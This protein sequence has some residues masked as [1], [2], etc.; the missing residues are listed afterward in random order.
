LAATFVTLSGKR[1]FLAFGG[2]RL[3]PTRA[4]VGR[5]L[6]RFRLSCRARFLAGPVFPFIRRWCLLAIV[7]ATAAAGTLVGPAVG[8]AWLVR[9]RRLSLGIRSHIL[10]LL[11]LGPLGLGFILLVTRSRVG[12]ITDAVLATL[13]AAAVDGVWR[14]ATRRAIAGRVTC[15]FSGGL[16]FLGLGAGDLLR[17]LFADVLQRLF[18]RVAGIV[19][20]LIGSLLSGRAR[21]RLTLPAAL[22][23]LSALTLATVRGLLILSAGLGL[24]GLAIA[25]ARLLAA[26]VWRAVGFTGHWLFAGR[27]ALSL[28]FPVLRIAWLTF[29]RSGLTLLACAL[30]SVTLLCVKGLS[31]KGLTIAAF[32]RRRLLVLPVWL[33]LIGRGDLG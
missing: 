4:A 27:G 33:R 17:L 1:T 10:I 5:F 31:V 15:R 19:D 12:L 18:K 29:V 20:R 16:T 3:L 11:V 25:A 6:V 9:A 14:R 26:G 32:V 28:T 7:A 23:R 21:L 22:W 30:L 8:R 24:A 13:I 2:I